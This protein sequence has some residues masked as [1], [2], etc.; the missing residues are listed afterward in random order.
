MKRILHI[1]NFN[2]LR[3][4]GCYQCGFPVKITNGLIKNGYEVINYPDRD[5]CR[6]FGF[7]HMNTIGKYRVNKHLIKFCK[8]IHPD[9]ILIGHADTITNESLE[10]IKSI[11]PNAPIMQWNCDP[12]YN[13]CTRN[14][15]AIN[16]RLPFVDSTMI[17]TA[18][19]PLLQQFKQGSKPVAHLPNMVDTAIETGQTYLQEDL[20]YDAFYSA[21][22]PKRNF[23]NQM[24]NIEDLIDRTVTKMPDFRWL[25]GGLKGEPMFHGFDYLNAFSK[26]AMGLSL[27]RK[28]DVYL[29]ASDRLAHIM[30]NGQMALIDG[31]A[32][33]EGILGKDTAGY[34]TSEDEF[35]DMLS[36]YKKNPQVRMKVAKLGHDAYFREFDNV[37]VTKHMADI[38]FGTFRETD[39]DWQVVV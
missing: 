22:E 34:Y 8:N 4:K 27:S 16:S 9:A 17:S 12:I 29:Y 11:F 31:R 20:P 3:L 28:N 23:C 30:G 19:K 39:R 36:F 37:L 13:T 33:F 24:I 21:G 5:L 7:G 14:I 6:M 10:K 38:L 18:D 15:N 2:L 35:F 32:G 26:A 1:A 25:L